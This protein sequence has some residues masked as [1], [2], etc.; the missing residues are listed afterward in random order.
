MNYKNMTLDELKADL[1]VEAKKGYP[2]FLS[3]ALYWLVMGILG[4]IMGVDQQLA[5]VFLLGTGSIFPLAILIGNMLKVNILSK[6]PLG[7]LG[8]IIGGIQCFYLPVWIVIYMEHYELI[9]MVIGVLGASHFLPYLW[10]YQS[11]IYLFLTIIMAGI[12]FVFGYIFIDQAFL[13]VPFSLAL[14]YLITVIGLKF[15]TKAFV[16]LHDN[17]DSVM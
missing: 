13:L 14:L 11:K 10:I 1:I 2:F 12:S 15:E 7:V 9:P 16:S 17:K 5:L 3:G 8:G 6:N 4:L